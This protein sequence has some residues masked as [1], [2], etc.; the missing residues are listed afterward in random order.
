MTC[1]TITISQI[2]TRGFR[3]AVL[4]SGQALEGQEAALDCYDRDDDL[5]ETEVSQ[6]FLTTLE[7]LHRENDKFKD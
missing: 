4:I 5:I 7:S 6:L 3:N 1:S 2:I